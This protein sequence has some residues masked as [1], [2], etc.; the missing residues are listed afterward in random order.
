MNE[1]GSSRSVERVGEEERM[2]RVREDSESDKRRKI[3]GKKERDN[4]EESD[5]EERV[6]KKGGRV[7]ENPSARNAEHHIRQK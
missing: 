6:D 3:K 7:T 2:K 4:E 5:D 1:L